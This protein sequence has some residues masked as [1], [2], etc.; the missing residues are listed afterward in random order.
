[1]IAS[2]S[3]RLPRHDRPMP[4]ATP[5]V[6]QVADGVWFATGTDTNWMLLRDGSD[7]T[8]IDSGYPGDVDAVEASV[9]QIGTRPE[10]VR[11]WVAGGHALEEQAHAVPSELLA[12]LD[13]KSL[14]HALFCVCVFPVPLGLEGA[15]E[16]RVGRAWDVDVPVFLDKVEGLFVT[17]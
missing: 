10:D 9:R 4:S 5:Y 1:M 7:V 13:E 2:P 8:L 17:P 3:A 12:V 14:V 6:T 11:A 16:K 15:H